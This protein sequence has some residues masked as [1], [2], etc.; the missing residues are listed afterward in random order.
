[1][2]CVLRQKEWR[3]MSSRLDLTL[4]RVERALTEG[5][6]AATG[7]LQRAVLSLLD[8]A[9]R[10]QIV[11]LQLSIERCFADAQDA[12]GLEFVACSFA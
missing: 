7:S 1:M 5:G 9:F 11:L 4:K 2:D 6:K 3:T 8:A 12:R 10:I